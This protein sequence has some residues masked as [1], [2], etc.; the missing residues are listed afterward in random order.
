VGAVVFI[1][2]VKDCGKKPEE[3]AEGG[4]ANCKLFGKI[5]LTWARA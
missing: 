2:L 5:A 3:K 4:G 1:G